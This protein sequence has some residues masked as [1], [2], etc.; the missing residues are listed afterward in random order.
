MRRGNVQEVHRDIQAPPSLRVG[1]ALR[2]ACRA[3]LKSAWRILVDE[4]LDGALG[5]HPILLGGI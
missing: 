2:G 4:L 1:G 5:M 3:R